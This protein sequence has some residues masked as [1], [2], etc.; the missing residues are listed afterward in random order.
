MRDML[1]LGGIGILC[2]VSGL[3]ESQRLR[4]LAEE[5]DLQLVLVV[6]ASGYPGVGEFAGADSPAAGEVRG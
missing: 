5:S 6:G 2:S 4:G 3:P 1:I